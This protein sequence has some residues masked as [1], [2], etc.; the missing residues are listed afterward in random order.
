M[1]ARC[2]QETALSEIYRSAGDYSDRALRC[3]VLDQTVTESLSPFGTFPFLTS[4]R[5]TFPDDQGLWTQDHGGGDRSCE[6]QGGQ[7][8]GA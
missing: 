3:V 4:T 1:S 5:M 2:F 7:R 6:A 8:G